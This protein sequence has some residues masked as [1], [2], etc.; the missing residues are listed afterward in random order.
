MQRLFRP[1]AALA[2]VFAVVIGAMQTGGTASAQTTDAQTTDPG[3][4]FVTGSATISVSPDQ[5]QVLLTVST[6]RSGVR[7]AIGDGNRAMTAVTDAIIAAGVDEAD[8]Q[9]RSVTLNAEYD[10]IERTRVLAGFRY[11]NAITVTVQQI[12]N[13][14]PVIDVAVDVGGNDLTIDGISFL[15]S[16]RAEIEDEARL[17]A[18]DNGLAK[19]SAMADRAGIDLGRVVSLRETGSISPVRF[20]VGFAEADGAAVPTPIFG[21]GMEIT[22]RVDMQFETF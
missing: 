10:F 20:D 4:L 22:V 8:I 17:F 13:V 6:L 15:V 2:I 11:R 5:G 18:I 21:G 16:N 19:A 1:L 12:E 7:A 14:G 9:T 3:A